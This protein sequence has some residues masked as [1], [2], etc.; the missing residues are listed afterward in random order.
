MVMEKTDGKKCGVD[1]I[2]AFE[3]GF[4]W[5]TNVDTENGHFFEAVSSPC[6]TIILIIQPLVDSGV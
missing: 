6:P 3:D 4:P 1:I 5:T 2:E